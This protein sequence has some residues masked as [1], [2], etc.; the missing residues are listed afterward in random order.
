MGENNGEVDEKIL[1]RKNDAGFT[2]ESATCLRQM[3]QYP[4]QTVHLH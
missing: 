1:V 2:F 3:L 4:R